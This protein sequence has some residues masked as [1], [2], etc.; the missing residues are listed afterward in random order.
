MPSK[1][2]SNP[3][4]RRAS[5]SSLSVGRRG[6]K[7]VLT[8]L[9]LLVAAPG[10][11]SLA[12]AGELDPEADV[13]SVHLELRSTVPAADSTVT[14]GPTEVRL[15]FSEPPQMDGTRVRIVDS[16]EELIPSSDVTADEEDP[17][18]VFIQFEARLPAD[19]YTVFWRTIAQDGH[20]QNGTFQF[21][22]AAAR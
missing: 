3:C 12:S 10:F 22:V 4:S 18:E 9:A 7:T 11:W 5:D 13:Q 21:Q 6:A 17:K 19:E 20:A 1:P 2:T 14:E 8:A 15:I 16:R